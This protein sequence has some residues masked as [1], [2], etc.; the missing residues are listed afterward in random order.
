[1]GARGGASGGG[2]SCPSREPPPPPTPPP[3]RGEGGEQQAWREP[4]QET[5]TRKR[6]LRPS[7][8]ILLPSPRARSAWRGRDERS[9]LCGVGG[10]GSHR[11]SPSWATP[12][13]RP[14][15]ARGEGEV[16][17]AWREQRGRAP[18]EYQPRQHD[19][20]SARLRRSAAAGIRAGQLR[21][22]GDHPGARSGAGETTWLHH[23]RRRCR[24][25]GAAAAQQDGGARRH[26]HGAGAGKAAARRPPGIRRETARS[27][28][29]RRTG[30]RARKNPKAACAS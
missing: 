24:R 18:S 12:P 5:S 10:G 17:Q 21:H 14:S 13:T 28:S 22:R 27:R 26:R 3:P 6:S 29:G 30:R 23:R 11:G 20:S 4:R 8:A 9:S 2:P 19:K 1:M 16:Q 15:P 25:A 7:R